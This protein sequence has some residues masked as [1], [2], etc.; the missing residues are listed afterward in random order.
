MDNFMKLL[1][2]IF[3]KWVCCFVFHKKEYN[4]MGW[5]EGE[6]MMTDIS[7]LAELFL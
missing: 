6:Q 7:F 1:C 3:V 4:H 5:H 2:C